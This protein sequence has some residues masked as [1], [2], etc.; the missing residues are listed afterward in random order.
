[1][2]DVPAGPSRMVVLAGGD[3]SRMESLRGTIYKAFLPIHGLS[4]I[5]RHVLRA[6]AFGISNV[7][8]IVDVGDP[9]LRSLAQGSFEDSDDQSGTSVQ[10]LC[11]AGSLRDKLQWYHDLL[12]SP[13]RILAVLGD[14]LAPVDL[15]ALWICSCQNGLDSAI[16]VAKLRLPFASVSV[17]QSKAIS[18]CEKPLMDVLVNTGYMVLGP[19]AL[20]LLPDA[21]GLADVLETMARTGRL[22]A[23]RSAGELVAV[24]SLDGLA[25]AHRALLDSDPVPFRGRAGDVAETGT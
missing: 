13:S 11:H 16:A 20:A 8:V 17:V 7:D 10:V 22:A 18:L 15:S 5:A 19:E 2:V 14:S 3:N 24:D 4:C 6:S 21:T 12:G 9:V 23:H 25:A 1:M